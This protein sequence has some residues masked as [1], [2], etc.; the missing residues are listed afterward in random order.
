MTGVAA[1][2]HK[3]RGIVGAARG[4]YVN[5]LIIDELAALEMMRL[6][7][8]PHEFHYPD[9]SS[10]IRYPHP[11]AQR[12]SPCRLRPQATE[13]VPLMTMTPGARAVARLQASPGSA[14]KKA[15]ELSPSLKE[16]LYL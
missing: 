3:A 7:R 5:T 8:D 2:A 14:E 6:A 4:G 11:P 10:P 9:P 16:F 13:P 12:S 1:G 15:R